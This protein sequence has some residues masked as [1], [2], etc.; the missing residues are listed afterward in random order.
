MQRANTVYKQAL[1]EYIQPSLDPA[2]R[3]ALD[4]FVDGRIREGGVA[5]DF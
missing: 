1:D 3:E 4:A 5:T 2:I